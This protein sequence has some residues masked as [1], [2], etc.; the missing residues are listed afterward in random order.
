MAFHY[1]ETTMHLM[2]TVM[3]LHRHHVHLLLD[4]DIFPGQ[5]PL[6]KRLTEKDGMSQKE[7]AGMLNVKPATLTVMIDRMEKTGFV[8][9]KSDPKDQRVSRVFL[10]GKGRRAA[11][12]VEEA[13]QLL[14]QYSFA[15]F[16]P[17]EELVLRGLI[18]M[19]HDN[20]EKFRRDNS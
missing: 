1:Q 14:N 10:T 2:G 6:L 15:G 19:V 5:P 18:Q 8:E 4:D 3:K 13:L 20:L 11:A 16:S 9:R 7:L 12:E 17:E